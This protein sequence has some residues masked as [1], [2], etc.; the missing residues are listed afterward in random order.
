[1]PAIRVTIAQD[2]LTATAHI[3]AGADPAEL[4]TDLMAGLLAERG[5]INS[6][7]DLAALEALLEG[8]QSDPGRTHEA[9]VARGSAPRHGE[10]STVEFEPGVLSESP[11]ARAERA[12]AEPP[13]P[14]TTEG[15]EAGERVDHYARS[16]FVAVAPGD[17]I[18]TI[19]KP[20]AGEDGCDVLGG[21]LR[22][23]D[24]KKLHFT[25]DESVE[26][27]ET[28]GEITANRPGQVVY[29]G[30]MLKVSD[31]L[32]IDE[33]VDFSTGH[34]S[35]PGHVIVKKGVRDR[36]IVRA[37]KTIVIND[38]VEAAELISGGTCMLARGMAGREI[39]TIRAG[40]DLEAKYLDAVRATVG[41]DLRIGR[42]IND[43]TID[44]G[45][46]IIAP[47]GAIIGG[48]LVLG[49]GGEVGQIGTEAGAITEVHLGHLPSLEQPIGEAAELLPELTKRAE[50]AQ[51]KLKSLGSSLGKSSQAA[52]ELT[53]LHFSIGTLNAKITPLRDRL[54]Q[55]LAL[56]SEHVQPE[57]T[58]HRF[59]YAKSR[60]VIGPHRCEFI[61]S[62]KGPVTLRLDGSGRPVLVDERT[63]SELPLNGIAKVT[64]APGMID[65]AAVRRM[66][67]A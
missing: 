11:R 33:Y 10:D 57:L 58:V 49:S 21:V 63:G 8:A 40:R 2:K 14:P 6:A 50:D 44:V 35:F 26:I 12:E 29:T 36:F 30:S 51:S 31:Q 59:I 56:L 65:L 9:I 54:T 37:S 64:P 38:L 67:A 27:N 3:D 66:L 52:D 20:T 41:R 32:I 60:I 7:I 42:E 13:P 53:N 25:T 28:T 23:K 34:V 19:R 15:Q 62:V 55:A 17:R 47:Q 45:R 43:C 39:G 1:M 4:T 46:S 5:V 22:A 48:K 18:G 61:E 16:A 24:G